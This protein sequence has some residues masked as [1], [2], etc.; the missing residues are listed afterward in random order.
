MNKT[1]ARTNFLTLQYALAVIL[2]AGLLFSAC[3]YQLEGGGYLNDS[4]AR[5]MVEVFENRSAEDD[6]DLIFTSALI[7]EIV[8]K[9]DTQ[10]VDEQ[11]ADARLKGVIRS[12]S[13]TTVSRS[14][15]ES[16]VERR[17]TATLDLKMIDPDGEVI[18]SVSGFTTDDEYEVSDDQLE[19]ESNKRDA[20]EDIAERAAEKIVS[21]MLTNF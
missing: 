10:V 5:V 3:G 4:Y 12:V 8:E 17:A 15:A 2:A 6:A 9:T 16:V 13:F 14:T 20:L 18:W 1:D 19:D 11:L 7:Q 21:R